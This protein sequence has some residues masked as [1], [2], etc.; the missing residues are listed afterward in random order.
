MSTLPNIFRL[1][2]PVASW[3]AERGGPALE[4]VRLLARLSRFAWRAAPGVLALLALI[5]LSLAVVPGLQVWVYKLLV[6]GV[7]HAGTPAFDRREIWFAGSLYIGSLFFSQAAGALLVPLDDQLNEQLQ[8]RMRSALLT[9]GER[10][11]GLAFY[12]DEVVQN[13]LE[14]ARR[15]LDYILLEAM[16][17]LPLSLQQ[18]AIALSLSLLLARLN[19]LLPL[20]L[21]G[22]ALPRLR[23]ESRI[24]NLIWNGLSARSP[25][26]RWLN[27]CARVLLTAEY[28]KEVRLFGLG[29]FFLA[30]YRETFERAH[31][32][33]VKLRRQEQRGGTLFAL[34]N[35]GMTGGAYAW[36]VL[37]AARRQLTVGDVALYTGAT[38]QLSG[39]LSLLTI[40]YGA[41]REDRL[42]LRTFFGLLDRPPVLDCSQDSPELTRRHG[43][44]ESRRRIH[45]DRQDGQDREN[46]V[47]EFRDVWF[48]YPGSASP[49]LRGINLRIAP[50]EKIAIVGENGAGKTTLLNLIARLYD[51]TEGEILAGG[52]PLPAF[53]IREWREQ[54][55]NVSQEFLRL[56]APL[57]SN[58]A[59]GNLASEADDS[60]LWAACEQ[61][62]LADAVRVLPNRLDQVLGRRFEGGVELSGG[63]WQKVAIARALL[64][65]HA[66]II[67]LDEPTSALDAPTEHALFHQFVHLAQ[68]RTAILVSHRFS[69]VSMADRIV[70][71]DAGAILEQGTHAEL[72]ARGG[73]YAELFSLQAARYR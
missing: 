58:L 36:I 66:S 22:S 44:T 28:A 32:E 20:L 11:T 59:L 9:V 37:A 56:E 48:T 29:D 61:A 27:Y 1:A 72:M 6:D 47:I 54:L 57:R 53:D 13:E 31:E 50:G 30:R 14:T 49:A 51:P 71:L 34:L 43:D 39:A 7:A 60:G 65:D 70:V 62:G 4:L 33:L 21:V 46:E 2:R 55:S 3:I 68:H 69:T 67:M 23:Y 63:E 5:H 24:R 10:Q 52:A 19:P 73:K 15:G 41:A 12:E 25:H 40:F 16:S 26:W 42:R 35:A 38:F 45:R 18:L 17:R 64:R 8:G